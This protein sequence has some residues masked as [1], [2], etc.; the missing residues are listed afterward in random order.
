MSG[1]APYCTT[2]KLRRGK[3]VRLSKMSPKRRSGSPSPMIHSSYRRF[4][5]FGIESHSRCR[6]DSFASGFIKVRLCRRHKP[7]ACILSYTNPFIINTARKS[8]LRMSRSTLL[9]LWLKGALQI[10]VTGNSNCTLCFKPLRPSQSFV[11]EA[12][13]PN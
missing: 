9:K 13:V 11:F 7:D 10:V 12:L 6:M 1:R 2:T 4:Q 5:S 3:R 8:R